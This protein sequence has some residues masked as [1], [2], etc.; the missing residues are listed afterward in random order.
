[1]HG[2]E[3]KMAPGRIRIEVSRPEPSLVRVDVVDDGV[4]IPAAEL[5]SALEDG[6]RDREAFNRIGLHNVDERLKLAFGEAYGL[7]VESVEG[8]YTRVSVL[9]PYEAGETC[10]AS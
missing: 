3:P 1:M 2:I 7:R 8:E 9:L 4:G 10:T 6:D 5:G